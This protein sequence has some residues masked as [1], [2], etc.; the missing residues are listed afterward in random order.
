LMGIADHL[1]YDLTVVGTGRAALDALAR[2]MSFVAVLMD[3]QMPEMDGY[4][5]ARAI[6][7]METAEGRAR[8]PIIAVTAH[9]LVG[10]RQKVLE[11]GMDDYLTK[12]VSVDQLR[13]KLDHWIEPQ[14]ASASSMPA[15]VGYELID[16]DVIE[17]LKQLVSPKRPRFFPNLVERFADDSIKHRAAVLDAIANNDPAAMRESAHSLKGA[18]RSVGALQV[19]RVSEKLE[20]LAKLGTVAGAEALVEELD[21]VLVPSIAFLRQTAAA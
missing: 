5:A 6:R 14:P 20:E 2:D 19:A 4:E 1:G 15:P 7:E 8:I 9:A 13:R 21:E 18:S 17:Q 3:C 11:A 10:E 16:G 12:P